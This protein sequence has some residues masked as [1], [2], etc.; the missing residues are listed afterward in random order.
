MDKRS[1]C[2]NFLSKWK[3]G[4]AAIAGNFYLIIEIKEAAV[5]N[6]KLFWELKR[7]AVRN[8]YLIMRLKGFAVRS[9]QNIWE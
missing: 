6:F 9:F 7:F 3:K 5:R 8:S 1:H 2:E 4:A